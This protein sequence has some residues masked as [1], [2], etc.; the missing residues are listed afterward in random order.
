MI[1]FSGVRILP[2]GSPKSGGPID[3]NITGLRSSPGQNNN[4]SLKRVQTLPWDDPGALS[5]NHPVQH[6]CRCVPREWWVFMKIWSVAARTS[7][8][9]VCDGGAPPEFLRLL[10]TPTRKSIRRPN[11]P[12]AGCV[13][14]HLKVQR[15]EQRYMVYRW[16]FYEVKSARSSAP[17]GGS[18]NYY[19]P[20]E[21]CPATWKIKGWAPKAM[22]G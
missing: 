22:P 21:G 19:Q 17:P 2:K 12:P 1:Y 18:S 5:G 20:V 3:G 9:N 4:A 15:D 6:A 7:W 16:T 14:K 10:F 11:S 8:E 13:T